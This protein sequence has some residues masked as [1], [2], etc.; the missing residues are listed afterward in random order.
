MTH[1]QINAISNPAD[2]LVVYCTDCG[3]VMGGGFLSMFMGGT[4]YYFEPSCLNPPSSPIAGTNVPSGTQIIWNWNR[5]PGG[6]SYKW[7][8]INDYASAQDMGYACYKQKQGLL[9]AQCIQDM[10]GHII[11]AVIHR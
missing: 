7:N 8:T 3:G 6:I 2:G 5:V 4:W 11:V 1:A 9:Q 10:S